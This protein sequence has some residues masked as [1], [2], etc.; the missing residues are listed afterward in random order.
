MAK[1]RPRRAVIF[2]LFKLMSF[3]VLALPTRIGLVLGQA[4]GSISFYA[5]N[6]ERKKAPS[7]TPSP[8]RKK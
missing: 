1:N 8:R 4:F 2:L 6:K 3:I 7:E 5:L